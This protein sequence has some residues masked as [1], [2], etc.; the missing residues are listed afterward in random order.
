MARAKNESIRPLSL[1]PDEISQ[2]TL[3]T[4]EILGGEAS[5]NSYQVRNARALTKAK[6]LVLYKN[7]MTKLPVSVKRLQADALAKG[8]H[9][10]ALAGNI[11]LARGEKQVAGD[12]LASHC[13]A[14]PQACKAVPFASL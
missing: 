2:L 1:P 5:V 8:D 9:S 6:T 12:G 11:Q 10:L 3:V 14:H 13:F 4:N 7:G